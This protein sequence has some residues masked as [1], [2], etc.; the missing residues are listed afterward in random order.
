MSDTLFLYKR[1]EEI[2][3]KMPH[4]IAVEC[5]NFS[6]DFFTLNE[7]ANKLAHY[8]ISQGVGKGISV[9]LFLNHNQDIP[10][11]VLAVLKSGGYY[12]PLSPYFPRERILDILSDCSCSIVLTNTDLP[13]SGSDLTVDIT[14]ETLFQNQSGTNPD[15]SMSE[16]D[17]VYVLYT[18]G[19]TGKPKGVIINHQ[20]LTYYIDWY[21]RNLLEEVGGDLPLMSSLSFAAAVKQLYVPLATGVC[22][23]ILP[24]AITQN[25]SRL[26]EWYGKHP[27]HGMYIVPTLWEEHLHYAKMNKVTSLPQFILLSGEPLKENLVKETFDYK[28]AIKLWNLYGP[29]E[30]VANITC[31][32]VVNGELVTIG[33]VLEGSETILVDESLCI[34]NKNEPG[35]MCVS[36]PGVTPGYLNRDE[37][38]RRQFFI[39]NG[40]RYYRT[41][42]Y[43]TYFS[44]GSLKHLG[45]KDRQVKI[46]GIRIEPGE[47][48]HALNTLDD[49]RESV[50]LVDSRNEY[51]NT[52]VAY[53]L[54]DNEKPSAYYLD[55]L[56]DLLPKYALPTQLF[57]KQ[58]FPKLAN[59]KID[60]LKLDTHKQL[61]RNDSGQYETGDRKEILIRIVRELLN[62]DEIA[63]DEN[64]LYLGINSITIIKLANRIQSV[65]HIPLFIGD[66]YN[67][68]TI[69]SLFELMN[70]LDAENV[71][72][73]P[74][75]KP[76][77]TED[78]LPLA[79]NQQTLWLVEK[80]KE[81][82]Q[83]YNIIFSI[84][85]EDAHF[86]VAR[87]QTA[88]RK[89]I[90]QND[91]LRSLII[92][93]RSN[94]PVRKILDDYK[95]EIYYWETG[96]TGEKE[97][98]DRLIASFNRNLLMDETR[99]PVRYLLF[100]EKENSYRLIV[101]IHHLLFDGYSINL[102]SHKL[103][104]Y[105]AET[106]QNKYDSAVNYNHF[107]DKQNK[108]ITNAY[109]SEG[110][111]YWTKRIKSDSYTLNLPLDFPRPAVQQFAGDT[112]FARIEYAQKQQILDFCRLKEVSLFNLLL[113]SYSILLHK[114]SSRNEFLI[115]FPY[116]NRDHYQYENVL[117]YFVNI[118]IFKSFVEKDDTFFSLL[119]KGQK[120]IFEDSTYWSCPLE[121][122]YAHLNAEVTP[123]MNPLYQVMFALHDKLMSEIVS[124]LS[125]RVE[126][127]STQSAKVDL[128]LEAQ[129]EQE[130]LLLKF[131]YDTAIF[132][133]SRIERFA[134]DFLKIVEHI[135]IAPDSL[136]AGFSLVTPS[137]LAIMQQW[138]RTFFD[139]GREMTVVQLFRDTVKKY[140]ERIAL[141]YE[142]Q[143]FTYRELEEKI[144]LFASVLAKNGIGQGQFIGIYIRPGIEMLLSI[145]A[146]MQLGAA[147]I[148]LDP[149]Y[150]DSRINHIISDSEIKAVITDSPDKISKEKIAV[151][152]THIIPSEKEADIISLQ[153]NPNDI[154]YVIYTSGST[155]VSKG[156]LVPNKGVANCLNWMKSRFEIDEQ[157]AFLYQASINFDISAVELFLP[158]ISGAT[159]VIT[160]KEDIITSELIL[161]TVERYHITI[162]QFVPSALWAFVE[163]CQFGY[164]STL[165][166]VVVGGEKL[167]NELRD[168]FFKKLDVRLIN[169]YGPTE[170]SIYCTSYECASADYGNVTIGKPIGNVRIY[171]LDEHLNQIPIGS[172]GEIFIA[173]NAL[174]AGYVKNEKETTERFIYHPALKERL[175][176]SGDIGSFRDDGNID[177][178]GRRDK[179]VKIRGFRIELAE[180]ENVLSRIEDIEKV[181]VSVQTVSASDKRIIAF[182]TLHDR[183]KQVEIA[184]IRSFL[185][186]YLP[187]YMLPSDFICM[188]SLPALPNG[189]LDNAELLKQY[190]T[191]TESNME[192]HNAT[193]PMSDIERKV[194]LIWEQILKNSN[195][196]NDDNFFEVGGHSLLIL[197]VQKYIQHAL[198]KNIMLI[199]LY[200]HTSV[201]SIAKLF[202]N[203][204]KVESIHNIRE[205]VQQRVN[206]YLQNN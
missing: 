153:T 188:D 134:H 199:D 175:F 10:L 115:A 116:A 93:D 176:R 31:S 114:Y 46:N 198:N 45:R 152:Q 52:L 128:Y 151:I 121:E 145:M 100:K 166:K 165:K 42:D 192:H 88:L 163:A 143:S 150:P 162:L 4:R 103:I 101:F 111:R 172:K 173:G 18:S 137:E 32:R 131:N 112:V 87:L 168:L 156:V 160:P 15:I 23:H 79:V 97:E 30:T 33:R 177:F 108:N 104:H 202:E 44:D 70:R 64:I 147:Y 186:R 113:T 63:L 106:E 56:K 158:L 65:F 118:V 38:N 140:P 185:L 181:C 180:I 204:E 78:S 167:P 48:E 196:S 203:E 77:L 184:E 132:K 107:V 82:K 127:L 35:E 9:G 139:D 76:V 47:I 130:G 148:P 133:K 84:Q 126:E 58:S 49:V 57:T 201:R 86:S 19:T 14:N 53:I 90:R 17:I 159:L 135:I 29:T 99:P 3:R 28:P 13:V 154:L 85:L 142:D 120:R 193:T 205:R 94:H 122:Y 169:Q 191:R 195:F 157:D 68:P 21:I 27:N 83:T 89:V 37:L 39:L 102:F 110:I 8:L 67:H 144:N 72:F 164:K 50:V 11:A 36:G 66:I 6:F 22:L 105:Y 125:V 187:K 95:P 81:V 91:V 190:N 124:E 40:K 69:N 2:A 178:W 7:K 98:Q 71:D 200:K 170:T 74:E 171:I 206:R 55:K 146:V 24:P 96:E 12:V 92:P 54:T 123:S 182:Y 194:R 73:E 161:K 1:F 183:E 43:A 197:K 20:N 138:N 61:I 34:V 80:T 59:G 155:G 136:I 60:I 119:S 129:D 25:S 117:G 141:R 62:N 16:T 26:F 5:E 51:D 179:Q 41:G 75:I 149:D 109:F 189:K 174:A